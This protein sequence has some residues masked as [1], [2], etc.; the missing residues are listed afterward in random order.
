M[1]TVF[2]E[3]DHCQQAWAS[4]SPRDRTEGCRGL[5]DLLAGPARELLPDRLDHL[6]LTRDDLERL[7][8][9]LAHLHDAVG[10]AARASAGCLEH[11]ALARKVLGECFLHRL[12]PLKGGDLR[13]LLFCPHPL[14]GCILDEVSKLQF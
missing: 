7:G 12:A 5:S 14:L 8:D 10:A 1:L 6:P 9:V 11:L 3:D 4:P 2:S 13:R